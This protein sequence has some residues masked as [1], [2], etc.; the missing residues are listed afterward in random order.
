MLFKGKGIAI[1]WHSVFYRDAYEPARKGILASDFMLNAFLAH[2]K[3]GIAACLKPLYPLPT[4]S[5]ISRGLRPI[6]IGSESAGTIG[7]RVVN[8]FASLPVCFKQ[9]SAARLS[10]PL[11]L[12]QARRPFMRFPISVKILLSMLPQRAGDKPSLTGGNFPPRR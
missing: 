4:R 7:P 9:R 8:T 6:G 12:Q 1:P 2:G 3:S 5:G 10:A 11:T